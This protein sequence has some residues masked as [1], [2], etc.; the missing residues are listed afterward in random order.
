[1]CWRTGWNTRR[2]ASL[3]ALLPWCCSRG[4]LECGF[5]A[6]QHLIGLIAQGFALLGTLVGVFTIAIGVGPRTVP[7][8]AYHVLIVIVLISGLVGGA[9]TEGGAIT[10][11][12]RNLLSGAWTISSA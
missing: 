9:P 6:S 4:C 3:K 7:D 2:L 10:S 8:V 5:Q 12:S 11:P 1:V